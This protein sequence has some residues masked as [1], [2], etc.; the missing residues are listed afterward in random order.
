MRFHHR[1]RIY[2][3]CLCCVV[4]SAVLLAAGDRYVASFSAG[5][6]YSD[7]AVVPYKRAAVVLGCGKYVRDGRLNLFYVYRIEAA[8]ELWHAGKIDAVLI[9]G[10]NSRPDYD[11]PSEMKADLVA[12]G[13]PADYITLDY[14]GFRTLDSV[15]R[16]EA[17]F[18]LEDY[19]IVSQPFHCERA[20]FL[21]RQKGQSVIGFCAVDVR[22]AGGVR[23]RFREAFAR[24]RSI[25]DILGRRP[26]RYGGLPETVNYR[27]PGGCAS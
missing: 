11:E 24:V 12:M 18:G 10:D 14:A 20:V 8:A 22:G 19:I 21:A 3:F 16:A 13:V 4:V 26:A 5:R 25:L 27:L 17:V 2:C 7:A 6:L 15:H 1:R 9:S 23:V